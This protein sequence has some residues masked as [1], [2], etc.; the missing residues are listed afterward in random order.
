M[1]QTSKYDVFKNID[2]PLVSSGWS[3]EIVGISKT[4]SSA[5][6]SSS[7][8]DEFISTFLENFNKK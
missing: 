8:F 2:K 4:K 3:E 7:E 6:I 5:N 1:E